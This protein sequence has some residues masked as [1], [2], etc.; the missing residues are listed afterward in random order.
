MSIRKHLNMARSS[1]PRFIRVVLID[2]LIE[3]EIKNLLSRYE[4]YTPISTAAVAHT[5]LAAAYC[6]LLMILRGAACENVSAGHLAWQCRTSSRYLEF[7]KAATKIILSTWRHDK[8]TKPCPP[9]HCLCH[10]SAQLST[11]LHIHTIRSNLGQGGNQG[12]NFAATSIDCQTP[13]LSKNA[14]SLN[15]RPRKFRS[16]SA[17]S[18]EPPGRKIFSLY[19]L[20]TCLLSTSFLNLVANMSAENTCRTRLRGCDLVA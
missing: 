4:I 2:K 20:P 7:E 16:M 18:T 17:A 19:S 6:L 15:S 11:N 13:L 14:A 12:P 1:V 9:R 3:F 8:Y 10:Q 5:H